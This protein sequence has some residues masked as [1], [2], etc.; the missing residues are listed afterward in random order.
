MES[1]HHL[2][3]VVAGVREPPARVVLRHR[4]SRARRSATWR[5]TSST[6]CPGC[7]S[8]SRRSTTAREI[9]VLTARRWP[10]VLDR[11]QLLR[12]TGEKALPA[13][14]G[15][16]L[17]DGKLDYFAN[18]EVSYTLRGRHARLKVLWNYEAPAGGGDTHA[19]APWQPRLGSRSCRAPSRSGGRSCTSSRSG[20]PTR[21]PCARRSRRGSPSC[22]KTRPGL[23]RGGRGRAAARRVPD[24]LPR[25]PRSPLRR[26]DPALPRLPEEP[27]LAAAWEKANM[28]AKYYV[29]T[30]AV[31]LSRR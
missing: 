30:Q 28:L 6:S 29:T 21:R 22:A 31:E 11:A 7:S 27:G 3:K 26:G 25:G 12:L 4:R 9:Q 1:V 10:T 18:G 23:A 16:R 19:H 13:D 24:S 8:R 17:K 14:L 20:P 15:R 2:M 5:R